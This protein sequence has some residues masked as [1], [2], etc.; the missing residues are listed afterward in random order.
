MEWDSGLPTQLSDDHW[1][2]LLDDIE[3]RIIGD[4]ANGPSLRILELGPRLGGLV[5]L[6]SDRH[7]VHALQRDQSLLSPAV[8]AQP[9]TLPF[10]W[11]DQSMDLVLML[12]SLESDETPGQ[13]LAEVR[14]VLKEEG[15]TIIA[16]V[17]PATIPGACPPF[18]ELLNDKAL[19]GLL[20]RFDLLLRS[21][22]S[23]GGKERTL[24]WIG[25]AVRAANCASL[26][27]NRIGITLFQQGK[28][29]AAWRHF[30]RARSIDPTCADALFNQAAILRMTGRLDH[31]CAALEATLEIAP[32]HAD[33]RQALEELKASSEPAL[34]AGRGL[35]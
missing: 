1:L 3:G 32:D 9:W 10:P 29:G 30:D 8:P 21:L 12:G 6:L 7:E 23:W 31:Y 5:T 25:S 34:T 13:T 2:R 20:G 33:A 22:L 27:H 18:P 26:D 35:S 17:N 16:V 28:L 11:P 24:V 15:E 4:R 14:R 19:P